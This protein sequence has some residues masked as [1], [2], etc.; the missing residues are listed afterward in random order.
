MK[1]DDI[2]FI[3]AIIITV[4]VSAF[5]IFKMDLRV[6]GDGAGTKVDMDKINN[7]V[8]QGSI[9]IHDAGHWEEVRDDQQ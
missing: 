1:T 8:E 7:M 4:A 9:S 2:K 5:V 3:A 6:S